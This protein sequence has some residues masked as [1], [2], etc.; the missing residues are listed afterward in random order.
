MPLA[1]RTATQARVA[2]VAAG[3]LVVVETMAAADRVAQ[4]AVDAQ[5]A[6]MAEGGQEALEDLLAEPAVR[7]HP[8]IHD[9]TLGSSSETQPKWPPQAGISPHAHDLGLAPHEHGGHGPG[10]VF[11]FQCV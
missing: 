2:A 3:G 1:D 5:G 11:E 9:E 10:A 8:A 6:A 4:M 7:Q